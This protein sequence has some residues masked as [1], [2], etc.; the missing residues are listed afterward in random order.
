[1]TNKR[2]TSP[3][4][5]IVIP[6]TAYCWMTRIR[7]LFKKFPR[8]SSWVSLC[9]V[10]KLVLVDQ[11]YTENV[12]FQFHVLGLHI[13]ILLKYLSAVNFSLAG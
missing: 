2:K 4:E 3:L 12:L 9:F 10:H 5:L 1:M 11:L 13:L 8:N 6:R 7:I